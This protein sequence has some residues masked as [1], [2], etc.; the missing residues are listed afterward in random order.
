VILKRVVA[1]AAIVA[2][3]GC[4]AGCDT[5]LSDGSPDGHVTDVPLVEAQLSTGWYLF[6]TETDAGWFRLDGALDCDW[7][8]AHANPTAGIE[9]AGKFKVFEKWTTNGHIVDCIGTDLGFGFGRVDT[10]DYIHQRT[11]PVP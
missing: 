6:C 4:L 3:A 11:S 10:C 9:F 8:S 7:A 1:G 2:A 5:V